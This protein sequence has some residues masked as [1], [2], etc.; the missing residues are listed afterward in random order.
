[1]PVFLGAWKALLLSYLSGTYFSPSPPPQF[2]YKHL[3]TSIC[4]LKYHG[5]YLV[6]HSS[7]FHLNAYNCRTAT[8]SKV[9]KK[10]QFSTRNRKW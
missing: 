1:M 8:N 5:E 2:T 10:R 3:T 4:S 9:E 7:V 6:H